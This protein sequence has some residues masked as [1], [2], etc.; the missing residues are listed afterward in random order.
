MS[1]YSE[2][3]D[4][5]SIIDKELQDKIRILQQEYQLKKDEV[6]REKLDYEIGEILRYPCPGSGYI[7]K[8]MGIADGKIILNQCN[9]Q[10]VEKGKLLSFSYFSFDYLERLSK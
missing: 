6:V 3:R 10:G 2:I 9:K 8:F 4:E 1:L 5:V 7:G